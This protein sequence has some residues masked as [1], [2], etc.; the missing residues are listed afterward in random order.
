MDRL[1]NR[2]M[3]DMQD[4]IARPPKHNSLIH[5]FKVKLKNE[6]LNDIEIQDANS[7]FTI[8]RD[9]DQ[10]DYTI[11]EMT[12]SRKHFQISIIDDEVFIKHLNATNRTY[13]NHQLMDGM[14]AY[15]MSHGDTVNIDNAVFNHDVGIS[16]EYYAR[17]SQQTIYDHELDITDMKV[18]E[19]GRNISCHICIDH[20]M[21]S[22]NHFNIINDQGMIFIEDNSSANGTFLNGKRIRERRQVQHNDSIF[23][24]NTKFIL[25]RKGE[26][27]YI[28]YTTI[29]EG[30]EIK[31]YNLTKKAFNRKTNSEEIY[32]DDVSVAIGPGEFVAIVGG[33]GAGKSTLMDC[34]N[35]FRPASSGEVYINSDDFER[36][37][38]LY[39][40][41]I[42]YVQQKDALY[43]TLSVYELLMYSAKL[44]MPLDTKIN[45]YHRRVLEVIEKV[46]LTDQ[47]DRMIR[48]LS[49]GQKKRVSIAVELISKPQLLFLDEPTSGL[50]PGMDKSM[51]ELLK[52]LSSIGTTIVLITH[53]TS[54]VYL[55]D[56]VI[57]MGK[58]GKLCYC[59]E[60]Q[61][62]LAHFDEE[63]LPDIYN[64]LSVGEEVTSIV[65]TYEYKMKNSIEYMNMIGPL[66][67]NSSQKPEN[68]QVQ[69]SKKNSKQLLVLLNR[70]YKLIFKDKVT[71]NIII[72]QAPIMFLILMLVKKEDAFE[73]YEGAKQIFFTVA[74]MITLM[75]IINSFLEIC[76]EKE[77]VKREHRSGV[78][79]ISY[80]L[81]KFIVLSSIGVIQ[82]T[83]FSIL[84][85]AFIDLPSVDLVLN[86]HIELALIL[87][88]TIIAA[89][90]M[91]LLISVLAKTS[92]QATLM[93]PALIILQLVFAGVLFELSGATEYISYVIVSKWSM[94]SLGTAIDI[95]SLPLKL[96]IEMPQIAE[97]PRELDATFEF[98]KQ[99][100]IGSGI[101]LI[102]LTILSMTISKI[103]LDKSIS[104]NER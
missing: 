41:M 3:I 97:I 64:K 83:I 69:K 46:S 36:N 37:Y 93:M 23:A 92:E 24:I 17:N 29:S 1:G 52:H 88:L 78:S 33:S 22:R 103:V 43:E 20:P 61:G 39:K 42:G 28:D 31:T 85:F 101:W 99:N 75:G 40:G 26:R 67:S 4:T 14:V 44:R 48:K 25:K 96:A 71:R 47:K 13:L 49:G 27:I 57:F 30:V 68:S 15:K 76:K 74:C 77:I 53:A 60:P 54:N 90:A 2:T 62:M 19:I 94:A 56:K 102:G 9:I 87:Y 59:G 51:M 18:V 84:L 6:P 95:N 34:M 58:G 72:L 8:G 100:L 80:L 21:I 50:D 81:S 16:I 82:V 35:R 65:A 55:C 38:E 89:T 70:Y 104:N 7:Q 63:E 73:T 91:G 32:L 86:S 98:T 10:C 11:D 79:A 45:E 66:N 5:V 12:V